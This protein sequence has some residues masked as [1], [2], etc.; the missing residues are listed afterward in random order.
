[1]DSKK[2]LLA[3][4]FLKRPNRKPTWFSFKYERLPNICYNCGILDHETR[5]CKFQSGG[6]QR[7]Y[8]NWLRTEDP[9]IFSVLWSEE[10]AEKGDYMLISLQKN[11]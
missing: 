8:D 9:E 7:L 11:C 4:L 5:A 1:M 3:E 2:P 10:A 6:K